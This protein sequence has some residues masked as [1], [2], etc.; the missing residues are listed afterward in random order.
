MCD[1]SAPRAR[2]N[3]RLTFAKLGLALLV[4][5]RE[6]ARAR[7]DSQNEVPHVDRLEG[8]TGNFEMEGDADL[9]EQK[10]R[11]SAQKVSERRARKEATTKRTLL[12]FGGVMIMVRLCVTMR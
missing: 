8:I 9:P 6:R 10:E 12:P 2:E 3:A 7:R 11:A 4:N 1:L 5:V